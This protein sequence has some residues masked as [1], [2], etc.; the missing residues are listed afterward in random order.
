[1]GEEVGGQTYWNATAEVQFPIGLLPRS[2]GIRG[3]LFADAGTLYDSAYSSD[4]QSN[5]IDT[6]DIRT[7]VGASI[8]WDSPFGPLRADFSHVLNKAD[9]DETQFFR[10]GVSTRF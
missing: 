3:A 5:I 8:L 2:Y 10:F 9:Q 1:T 7:S 6:D 4:P